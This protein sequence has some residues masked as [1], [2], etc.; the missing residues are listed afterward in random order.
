VTRTFTLPEA[1]ALIPVVN[2]LLK[3]A[4][5]AAGVATAREHTLQS[6]HH[7]I[8]LSGGMRVDLLQVSRLKSEHEKSV[9]EAR[10]SIGEIDEIG[11]HVKDLDTGLLEFPFQLEDQIVLLC[12][13][14]GETAIQAWR[15][16][17]QSY[18]ERQPLDDRFTR[19]ERP[20]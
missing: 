9:G 12:W 1:Q 10:E 8:F 5:A 16:L 4:Q 17:D 19:G 11:V 13:I 14:Q 18:D 7:A 2:A 20:H 15:T 6:L 3:R